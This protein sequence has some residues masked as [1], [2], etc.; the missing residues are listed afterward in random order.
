LI[1]L[2]NTREMILRIIAVC[3]NWSFEN[4]SKKKGSTL[5]EV[6]ALEINSTEGH[7]IYLR[8]INLF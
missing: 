7:E 8:K 6:L 2:G 4:D 3:F 1:S 5:E